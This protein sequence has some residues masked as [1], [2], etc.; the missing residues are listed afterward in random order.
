MRATFFVL[1]LLGSV[2]FLPAHAFR[3]S[4]GSS[5]T[6][7]SGGSVVQDI[8]APPGHVIYQSGYTGM[9]LPTPG[10]TTIFWNPAK[11]AALPREAHD[12]IFFHECA[13]AR[14]PTSD[15]VVA[16]CEGLKAMRAAGRSG[17]QVEATLATYHAALGYMGPRYGNGADYWA[18]TLRC[19]GP[20]AVA[21]DPR[22]GPGRRG[23]SETR[24]GPNPRDPCQ[25]R[26]SACVSDIP[27]VDQCV[28]DEY[29]QACID[30]CMDRFGHSYQRC[31]TQLCQPTATNLSSWRSRCRD[32]MREKRESCAEA[33]LEC[34]QK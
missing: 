21:A 33:R 14:V 15:E 34:R 12:F 27:S 16:N 20:A 24:P 13:H 29:P 30:V 23:E 25:E 3:F 18:K 22:P 26:Y 17:A 11:L 6:C 2:L 28:Q 7:R 31:A 32:R 5:A 19:A 8:A 4:D 9:T 10:G 1:P